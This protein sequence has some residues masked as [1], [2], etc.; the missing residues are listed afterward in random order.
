MASGWLHTSLIPG[1]A[2]GVCAAAA[3]RDIHTLTAT[4]PIQGLPVLREALVETLRARGVKVSANDLL[5]TGGAQQGINVV[6]R[7]LVSPGDAVV[8]ESPTWHGAFRAFRA[9]GANVVGVPLDRDGVDAAAL[10]DALLRLRPKL[11]YL[12]PTFHCPTG[13]S[14][15]LPRRRRVLEICARFR[16]PILESQVY[17]DTGFGDTLPSL[18]S[19][20]RSG[21]VIQQGSV[22]KT[23][24]AALRLGWLAAP[25]AAME[26]LAVSKATLDLSTPTLPQAVLAAFLAQGAYARHLRLLRPLLRERRDALLAALKRHCPQLHCTVPQGGLYLWAQ[27]PSPLHGLEVEAAAAEEGVAVR[28]GEAFAPEGGRSGHIRLCYAAPAADEIAAGAERLGRALSGLLR[29]QRAATP[30]DT[31]LASV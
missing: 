28:A 30:G 13:C 10:E 7:A 22:S 17:G 24:G 12:I 3:A 29:R 15:T 31:A 26:L 11:V 8:C 16:T 9:A 4:A 5:V 25:T 14:M 21:I 18:R 20:D 2:L 23:I 6:A 27:L 1:E 19:L